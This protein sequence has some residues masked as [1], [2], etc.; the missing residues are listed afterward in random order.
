MSYVDGMLAA[1]PNA[2]KERYVAHARQAAALFKEYGATSYVESWGDDVKDGKLTDFN[3]AVQKAADET[4]VFSWIS[5]PDKAARDA[6]WE[7][8]MQDPRMTAMQM[9]FDGSRMVYGGF[10]TLLES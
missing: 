7:K 5:W 2:N 4:V 10:Q 8:L 9:P 6:A 3:R 1:V